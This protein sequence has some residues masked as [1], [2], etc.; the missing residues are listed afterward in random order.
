VPF[1]TGSG[2]GHGTDQDT[3][4]ILDSWFI[5]AFGRWW[6]GGVLEAWYRD[7]VHR[8]KDEEG[9]SSGIL[10]FKALDKLGDYNGGWT[11]PRDSSA[12]VIRALVG[13]KI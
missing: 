12:L 6:R 11:F 7:V 9:W 1:P 8:A 5:G 10:G 4:T 3:S 2:A 13:G